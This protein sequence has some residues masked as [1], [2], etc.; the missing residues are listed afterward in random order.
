LGKDRGVRLSY[1]ETKTGPQVDDHH[2]EIVADPYRWLEDS[3]A[4][5]TVGWIQTQNTLT[6]GWLAAIPSRPAIAA[7]LTELWDYPRFGVPIERGGQWFQF[8]NSGLQAQPVLYAMSS[9]EAEG[10]V[11]LDPNVLS[12]DGTVAVVSAEPT[13]TA[14]SWRTRRARLVRIG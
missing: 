9:P 7:R 5:A 4:P 2:G 11:L 6:E 12:A 13:P 14:I 8:R 3:D 1:P 10:K